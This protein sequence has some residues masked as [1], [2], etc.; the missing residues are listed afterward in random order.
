M[1]TRDLSRI[2]N[3]IRERPSIILPG[4]EAPASI[5]SLGGYVLDTRRSSQARIHD[6]HAVRVRAGRNYSAGSISNRLTI[7]P[8]FMRLS[9]ARRSMAMRKS[10]T[11]SDM[12]G[13]SNTGA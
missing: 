5:F 4:K 10:E 2:I 8:P 6:L 3:I 13:T 9:R 12:K 1:T 7:H 11:P